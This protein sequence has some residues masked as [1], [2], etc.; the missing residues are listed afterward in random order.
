MKRVRRTVAYLL[1]LWRPQLRLERSPERWLMPLI[2]AVL[3]LLAVFA[4]VAPLKI[5]AGGAY[6]ARGVEGHLVVHLARGTAPPSQ[7][8]RQLEDLISRLQENANLASVSLATGPDLADALAVLFGP[9]VRQED[10]LFGGIVRLDLVER[11]GRDADLENL[12]FAVSDFPSANVDDFRTWKEA[13]R[14]RTRQ[15]LVAGLGGLTLVLALVAAILSLTVRLALRMHRRTLQTLHHLGA[16]D[17][18]A[19]LVFQAKTF[20]R[21]ALGSGAGA[22]AALALLWGL[23]QVLRAQGSLGAAPL[24]VAQVLVLILAPLTLTAFA[25]FIARQTALRALRQTY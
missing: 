23:G 17:R 1:A 15:V 9:D 24:G 5:S 4:A 25:V 21:A 11:P 10:Q 14:T 18:F 12:Q 2:L 6:E 19:A 8:E 20:Q 3:T 22:L 7:F 16:T 13:S